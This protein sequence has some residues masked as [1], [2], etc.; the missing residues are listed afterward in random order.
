MDIIINTIQGTFVVPQHKQQELIQWL[1][2]NAVK[3]GQQAV[4]EQGQTVS[5]NPYTGRQLINEG[6]FKGEF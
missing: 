5:Q 3:A 2:N 1:I 6:V 4:Y